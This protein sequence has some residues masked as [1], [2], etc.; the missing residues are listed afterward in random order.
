MF[1]RAHLDLKSQ[2]EQRK[3]PQ[4][5]KKTTRIQTEKSN[6]SEVD[7]NL[8]DQ[9]AIGLIFESD[10]FERRTSFLGPISGEVRQNQSNPKLFLTL[11]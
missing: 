7:E 9:V 3:I 10:W 11:I 4:K 5:K 8:N 1:N 2:S 6:L